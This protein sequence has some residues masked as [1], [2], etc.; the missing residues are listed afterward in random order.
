MKGGRTSSKASQEKSPHASDK[1]IATNSSQKELLHNENNTCFRLY[2]HQ[3][4]VYFE[5]HPSAYSFIAWEPHM[6]RPPLRKNSHMEDEK[7]EPGGNITAW[8]RQY[9]TPSPHIL[10]TFCLFVNRKTKS[11]RV[12]ILSESGHRPNTSA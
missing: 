11:N 2:L 10:S 4:R 3:R 1:H 5:R 9:M 8:G 12:L 7:K 6:G